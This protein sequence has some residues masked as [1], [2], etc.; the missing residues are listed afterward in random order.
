LF[1]QVT[2]LREENQI[3]RS[4]LPDRITLSNQERRKLVRHGQK[5]GARIKEVI[6]I[7]S[8]ST[9]R[10]W[11]RQME[12]DEL[13][14]KSTEPKPAVPPVQGRPKTDED[15]RELI[16]R[17]RTETGWGY[18]KIRQALNRLG[19]KV[20]RQTVSNVLKEAGLTPD[21]HADPD[22][23]NKFLKRHADTL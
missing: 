17:I 7:V 9:F 19:H 10:R 15:V 14:A 22:T 18:T 20:S 23:W 8:Y 13:A 2:Y 6:S 21:P 5:L 3:L 16:I 12:G 4:K 11:V 1:R